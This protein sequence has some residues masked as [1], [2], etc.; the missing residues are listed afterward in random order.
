MLVYSDYGNSKTPGSSAPMVSV[1]VVTGTI[2]TLSNSSELRFT[3]YD[4]VHDKAVKCCPEPGQED[5]VT[6][7]RGRRA[8]VSGTIVRD[9]ATGIP[10]SIT[11][12]LKIEPLPDYEPGSYRNARGAVSWKKGDRMPED[13]IRDLRDAW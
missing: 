10:K 1:G 9:G 5:L 11:N 4:S 6:E 12:I 2:Q 8:S 3:I 13:V 7:I